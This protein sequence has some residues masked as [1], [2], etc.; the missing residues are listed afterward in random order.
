VEL[1][2][3]LIQESLQ[4]RQ[5]MAFTGINPIDIKINVRHEASRHFWNKKGE[6]LKE[7]INDLEMKNKNKNITDL[8]R[9]INEFR[10]GYQLEQLGKQEKSDLIADSH[11]LYRWKNYFSLLLNIHGVDVRQNTTK[12]SPFGTEFATEKLKRYSDQIPAEVIQGWDKTLCSE[13]HTLINS[14]QNK[15]LPQQG[16]LF[17][18]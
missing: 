9:D 10:E 11:I 18:G 5:K 2:L 7:K 12:S 1:D 16:Y 8:Y 13:I 17:E 6:Y 4:K 3:H 15:E 14:I